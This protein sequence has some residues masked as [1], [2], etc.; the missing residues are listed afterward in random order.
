M[1]VTKLNYDYLIDATTTTT[2]EFMFDSNSNFF[3]LYIELFIPCGKTI[4]TSLSVEYAD[5]IDK[6]H[7]H[8]KCTTNALYLIK[9]I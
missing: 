4:I 5:S 1:K 8:K 3:L 6:C 2:L 7:Y 9:V